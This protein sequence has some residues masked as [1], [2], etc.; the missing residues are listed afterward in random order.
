V[1]LPEKRILERQETKTAANAAGTE[2]TRK[3]VAEARIL[4]EK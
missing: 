3:T 2:A 1:T 4:R